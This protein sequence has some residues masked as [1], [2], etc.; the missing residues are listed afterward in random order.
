DKGYVLVGGE[1]VVA[2]GFFARS[3][4]AEGT[5]KETTI[6]NGYHPS[7]QHPHSASVE[8]QHGTKCVIEGV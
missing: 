4:V 3:D 2:N 7:K 1:S 6:Q 5:F 8:S